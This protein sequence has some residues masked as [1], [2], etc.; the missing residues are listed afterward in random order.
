MVAASN[1]PEGEISP[2]NAEQDAD[3]PLRVVRKRTRVDPELSDDNE[4]GEER[5]DD[6]DDAASSHS[7]SASPWKQQ[8]SRNNRTTETQAV[9]VLHKFSDKDVERYQDPFQPGSTPS[10]LRHYF[11]VQYVHHGAKGVLSTYM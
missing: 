3:E 4:E 8:D 9:E 6:D 2:S 11:M 10:H 5:D 7:S 1:N